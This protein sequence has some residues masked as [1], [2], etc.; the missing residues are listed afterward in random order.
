M[1]I[2]QNSE[3]RMLLKKEKRKTILIP[4]T[5]IIIMKIYIKA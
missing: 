3:E 2:A 4:M 1:F 5:E